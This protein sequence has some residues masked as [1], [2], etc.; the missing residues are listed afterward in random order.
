MASSSWVVFL[1]LASFA[2]G[3]SAANF[4]VLNNCSFTVWPVAYAGGAAARGVQL[5]AGQTWTFEVPGNLTSYGRIW[6]RTGCNFEVSDNGNCE[7]GSC[8]FP[9]T[10][11]VCYD[12][13]APDKTVAEFR[14]NRFGDYTDFDCNVA[15]EGRYNL[16]MEFSCYDN[17]YDR[18]RPSFRLRC[19]DPN[20]YGDDN[21]RS[22]PRVPC[23]TD[24]DYGVTFCPGPVDDEP[25]VDRVTAA[26]HASYSA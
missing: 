26:T 12:G 2:A 23:K 1:L 17:D 21:H 6:G 14:R 4:A 13:G 19:T 11:T 3:A 22:S 15:V 16:P 10:L 9:S 20:C 7:T 5:D 24:G 25:L 8:G 18:R